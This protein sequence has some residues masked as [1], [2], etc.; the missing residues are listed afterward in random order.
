MGGS[1]TIE[2]MGFTTAE[3]VIHRPLALEDEQQRNA[4]CRRAC[5][6]YITSA[7]A[8]AETGE[9]INN[10]GTVNRVA[11]TLSW[12]GGVFVAGGNKLTRISK[13]HERS[14]NVAARSTNRLSAK[15]P[16]L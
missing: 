15:R 10:D 13:R 16:A 1:I 4:T 12:H 7:N 11:A 3:A 9:S 2:Q 6:R 8:I 5:G 14:R